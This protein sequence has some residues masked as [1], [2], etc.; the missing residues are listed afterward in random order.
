MGIPAY[1]GI[2]AKR[3]NMQMAGQNKDDRINNTQREKLAKLAEEAIDRRIQQMRHEFYLRRR[4]IFP[5][6][7]PG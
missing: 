5:L 6:A 7:F 1:A 3:R 4:L 2:R